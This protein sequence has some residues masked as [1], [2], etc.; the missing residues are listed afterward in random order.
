[1][2]EVLIKG[3]KMGYQLFPA[4]T[5]TTMLVGHLPASIAVIL[6]EICQ[7]VKGHMFMGRVRSNLKPSDSK[8]RTCANWLHA[9][10]P[11]YDRFVFASVELSNGRIVPATNVPVPGS[12]PIKGR[13]TWCRVFVLRTRKRTVLSR[14][15][16]L[17]S[18]Y[19]GPEYRATAANCRKVG[20]N[21]P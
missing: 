11:R 12:R 20:L 4:R 2:G 10:Y 6:R 16:Y 19:T 7:N 5:P 3:K 15:T 1:M 18:I 17:V 9:R 8:L 13:I 14:T 21:V